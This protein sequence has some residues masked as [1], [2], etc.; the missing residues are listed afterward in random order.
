MKR[1]DILAQ[2]MRDL[3]DDVK[4]FTYISL[5][6]RRKLI[7]SQVANHKTAQKEVSEKASRFV[8]LELRL[9]SDSINQFRHDVL[10]ADTQSLSRIYT[11]KQKII[12]RLHQIAGVVGQIV[13]MSHWQSPAIDSAHIDNVG[14]LKGKILAHFNDYTRD[15]HVLGVEFEKAYRKQYIPIPHTVPVFT[16]VTSSGMAAMTTAA[17]FIQGETPND[18]NILMGKSCYFET[19]QLINKL[20]GHRVHEVDLS[21]AELARDACNKYVP[22]AIFADTIGNEPSMR[23]VEI[24]DL[25]R[26]ASS[27]TKN[28]VFIICDPSANTLSATYIKG[29]TL[30]KNVTLLGIE[31]QNKLL[32]FG[33]D[34][35]CAGVV[36]GTGYVSQKLYDYRDHAGTICPDSTI[37]TL[38]T[39]N[40]EMAKLYT[41]RLVRNTQELVLQLR[42]NTKAKTKKINVIYPSKSQGAYFILHWRQSL[43]HSY[44]R[45]IHQVVAAAKKSDIQIVHGTSFG[46][47]T[48]RIYTVAMHTEYSHSFLRVAAGS[49]TMS[50]I[51]ELGE[52]LIKYL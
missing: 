48:T 17:L 32:Q 46:L 40:R 3:A 45:Y 51:H 11:Q 13:T 26:L 42:N 4:I 25:V 33:L 7:E 47:H 52:L 44:N 34:R 20:F 29:F 28:H 15:M 21:D 27:A 41:K 16:F 31:S 50:Q 12:A 6:Y 36:W 43:L 5:D 37:A 1:T 22:V 39:P 2:T 35:V 30:P 38:P 9:I 14:S 23:Q 49:E 18:G 8:E 10:R 24:S 19:K